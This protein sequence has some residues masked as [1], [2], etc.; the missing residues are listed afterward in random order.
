MDEPHE[1]RTYR[2]VVTGPLRGPRML[3]RCCGTPPGFGSASPNAI[4][5]AAGTQYSANGSSGKQ[6]SHRS[7]GCAEAMTGCLAVRAWWL[8]WRRGELSQHSVTPHV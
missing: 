1:P 7:P 3:G 4:S 8:M 6:Y 2:T 5:A